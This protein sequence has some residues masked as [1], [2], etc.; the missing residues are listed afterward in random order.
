MP[1]KPDDEKV[2]IPLDQGPE[3]PAPINVTLMK[4]A[5]ELLTDEEIQRAVEEGDRLLKRIQ[6][7]AA[8]ESKSED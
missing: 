2:V 4:C 7:R 6:D 8:R 5:L 1:K 3:I